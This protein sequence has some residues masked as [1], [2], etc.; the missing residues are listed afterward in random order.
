MHETLNLQQ[1]NTIK[2]R[3][4]IKEKKSK[5]RRKERKRKENPL[6]S[7]WSF[8]YETKTQAFMGM[9]P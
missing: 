6:P 8:L 4:S 9:K 1:K 2:I 5:R 7:S 3:K